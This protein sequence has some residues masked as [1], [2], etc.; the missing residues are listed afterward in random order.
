VL[1][2]IRYATVAGTKSV[3]SAAVSQRPVCVLP[4][5]EP[6]P[7]ATSDERRY[8]IDSPPPPPL[9]ATNGQGWTGRHA[10]ADEHHLR[11]PSY[12]TAATTYVTVRP[13]KVQWCYSFYVFLKIH[14]NGVLSFF[15]KE[16]Y[17]FLT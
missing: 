1:N 15:E 3:Q 12:L 16:G 11:E 4:T 17:S 13:R 2:V 6:P 8:T 14:R 9:H 10:G 7:R 5:A